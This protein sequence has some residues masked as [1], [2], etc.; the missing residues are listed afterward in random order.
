[1]P[2]TRT[3]A[4]V[5]ADIAAR[6]GLLAGWTLA[7]VPYDRFAPSLVPDPI[8]ATVAHRSYAVGVVESAALRDRQRPSEGVETL[9]RAAVRFLARLQPRDQ[10]ASE[11]AAHGLEL[12]LLQQLLAS[13]ATWPATFQL[14]WV[15]STRT[16]TPSGEWFLHDVRI[17]VT[18]RIPLQ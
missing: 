7:S 15:G 16:V 13:T 6:V 14:A 1:M 12:A 17:D 10:I 8:P 5:R 2:T 11:D 18:H 9:T 3:V 4:Q